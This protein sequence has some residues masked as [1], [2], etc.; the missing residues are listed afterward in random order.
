M[1]P[2][3]KAPKIFA[4]R[5][6]RGAPAF[7]LTRA[8]NAEVTPLLSNAIHILIT[9]LTR[10]ARYQGEL[11]FVILLR[12]NSRE[13]CINWEVFFIKGQINIFYCFSLEILGSKDE[14]P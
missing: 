11:I 6:G 14:Q 10:S 7:K 13:L 9:G 8:P 4:L 3:I 1:Q 12:V 5:A 2:A